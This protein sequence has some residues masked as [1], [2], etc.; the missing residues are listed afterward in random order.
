VNDMLHALSALDRRNARLEQ[1]RT[2]LLYR[3]EYEDLSADEQRELIQRHMELHPG[4]EG[5]FAEALC[6]YRLNHLLPEFYRGLTARLGVDA[7]AAFR[8]YIGKARKEELEALL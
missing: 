8:S 7:D 1:E 4:D 3:R 5:L 2:D 6:T